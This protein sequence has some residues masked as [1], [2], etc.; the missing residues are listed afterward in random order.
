[1]GKEK[2]ARDAA[3]IYDEFESNLIEYLRR[4]VHLMEIYELN[5]KI[6]ALYYNMNFKNTSSQIQGKHLNPSHWWQ[7]MTEVPRYIP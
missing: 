5:K 3:Y 6:D 4:E 1:M 2:R 7:I